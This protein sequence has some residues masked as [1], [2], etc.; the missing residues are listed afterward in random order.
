MNNKYEV[1]YERY[2]IGLSLEEVAEELGVTRQC[3]F[4]AFKRRGYILR[5]ANVQPCK[6]FNGRKC[7]L[8]PSGYYSS[9]CKKRSLMHRDVWEYFNWPIPEGFDV[10]HKDEDKTNN[11]LE[12]LECLP[13]SEHTRLYSKG[14][15]LKPVKCLDTQIAYISVAEAGR[16]TGIS[17]HCVL[18][19]VRGKSKTAGGLKW[20]YV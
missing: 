8:R 7:T 13:K 15:I 16:Q 14:R 11:I 2:K 6:F 20:I 10:H 5:A 4:T 12:N 3:V 18:N 17:R 1:G 9:T 19:C